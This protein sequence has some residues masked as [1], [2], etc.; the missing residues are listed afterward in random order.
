GYIVADRNLSDESVRRL[1]DRV[2]EQIEAEVDIAHSKASMISL[3]QQV[4]SRYG[5]I[6]PEPESFEVFCPCFTS[7]SSLIRES[8][9][10]LCRLFSREELIYMLCESI[11]L[12]TDDSFI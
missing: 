2:W 3:L 5:S 7:S 10:G 9:L 4:Y 11:L 6:L 1:V 12:S 8:V